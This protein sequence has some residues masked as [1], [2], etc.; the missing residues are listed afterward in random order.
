MALN[1]KDPEADRLARELAARTGE[2]ITETVVKALR[3]RLKRETAKAPVE[4]EDE[5][6]AIS[7]RAGRIPRRT[8]RMA[9][10][11]IGYDEKGLPR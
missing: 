11:I 6:M 1:I 8:G 2:S 3:E 5:I 7:R 4:L 9:D 10:E